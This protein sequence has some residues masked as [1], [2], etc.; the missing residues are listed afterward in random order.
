MQ[1]P[2][3]SNAPDALTP[4]EGAAL[5]RSG[6][7]AMRA[8]VQNAPITFLAWQP[9]PGEWCVVEVIGHL[10]ETE[11]RGFGGRFRAILAEDRPQFSG[12]DPDGVAAARADASRDPTDV[13]AEFTA[14]RE[15][16]IALLEGLSHEI[17]ERGGDHPEV[18]ELTGRALLQEWVNHDGNHIRQMLA[19]LQAYTWPHMGNAQ[20][21]SDG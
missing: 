17:L 11:E 7:V 13:L 12:W 1:S 2:A 10:V 9:A 4:A 18:G 16:N 6:L 14:R 8:L 19:N 5:L 3:T 15:A 20:R 21:F